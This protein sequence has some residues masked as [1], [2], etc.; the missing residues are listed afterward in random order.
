VPNRPDWARI[1]VKGG[2]KAAAKKW[3]LGHIVSGGTCKK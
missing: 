2:Q 3:G 1:A